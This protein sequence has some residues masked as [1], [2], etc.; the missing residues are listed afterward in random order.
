VQP[1]VDVLQELLGRRTKDLSTY[2][3]YS[4]IG[5]RATPKGLPHSFVDN[6]VWLLGAYLERKGRESNAVYI[7]T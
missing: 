5:I 6:L 1:E 7:H 2:L 4:L 3:K